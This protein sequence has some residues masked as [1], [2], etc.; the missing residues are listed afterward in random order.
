MF[1]TRAANLVPDLNT[2]IG[3]HMEFPAQLA[4]VGDAHGVNL[5]VAD[6]DPTAGVVLESF[7][8]EAGLGDCL[9]NLAG[10]GPE[11]PDSGVGLGN[12]LHGHVRRG[13][14]LHPVKVL[15]ERTLADE[16]PVPV[17]GHARHRQ[18]PFDTPRS[19]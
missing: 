5:A 17:L 4:D 9:E 6:I 7:V 3:W 14:T 11:Q 12:V 15:R 10:V 13:I 2:R 8:S 1:V 19:G 16:H 18:V